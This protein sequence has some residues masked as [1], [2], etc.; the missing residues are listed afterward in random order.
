MH[1]FWENYGVEP[2]MFDHPDMFPPHDYPGTEGCE[3]T[4]EGDDKTEGVLHLQL[5]L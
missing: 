1:Y 2:G 3:A 5:F 4:C